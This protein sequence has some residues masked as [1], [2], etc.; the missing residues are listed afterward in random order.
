MHDFKTLETTRLGAAINPS[1]IGMSKK[2]PRFLLE[3]RLML[4]PP[5]MSK[6]YFPKIVNM[7]S[8]MA[9]RLCTCNKGYGPRDEGI[10][11]DYLG[12]PNLIP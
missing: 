5:K 10:L 2:A 6:F 12:G 7:V 3:G 1:N 11:L 8:Y 4:P 9:K